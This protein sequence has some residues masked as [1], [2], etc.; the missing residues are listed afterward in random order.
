MV[1]QSRGCVDRGRDSTKH[2]AD[3]SPFTLHQPPPQW[4]TPGRKQGHLDENVCQHA[5]GI[6][7][8]F[9][10]R[11]KGETAEMGGGS[12][13]R[14]KQKE[15][16]PGCWHVCRNIKRRTLSSL[17]A[18]WT[19]QAH[20]RVGLECMG[21]SDEALNCLLETS[22]AVEQRW[23]ELVNF[24]HMICLLHKWLQLQ[25]SGGEIWVWY[26]DLHTPALLP[27]TGSNGNGESNTVY[28]LLGGFVHLP[29]CYRPPSSHLPPVWICVV[30]SADRQIFIA[31]DKLHPT[32][33]SAVS[34]KAFGFRSLCL[35]LISRLQNYGQIFFWH[36]AKYYLMP[37]DTNSVENVQN[38]H[39]GLNS[40][41][42]DCI[43]SAY[44]HTVVEVPCLTKRISLT[45][46][47]CFTHCIPSLHPEGRLGRGA[48]EVCAVSHCCS[49]AR[50]SL[51]LLLLPRVI[52]CRPQRPGMLLCLQWGRSIHHHHH[53]HLTV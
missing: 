8:G 23:R 41:N 36:A 53:H 33:A 46:C 17:R 40:R 38:Q 3:L 31:S 10:T 5:R 28:F 1:L 11:G 13:R 4:K 26:S 29:L 45:R 43:Q 15:Q 50:V 34:Q 44:T 51:H 20:Q 47:L 35:Y 24:I 39:A 21:E 19:N 22:R 49:H 30:I 18:W 27:I 48:L 32:S 42:E 16:Q 2:K 7:N 25:G 37:T 52:V 14:R 6:E 12:K 9:R